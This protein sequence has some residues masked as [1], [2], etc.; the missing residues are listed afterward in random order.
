V[1]K[2]LNRFTGHAAYWKVP[3]SVGLDH[4]LTQPIDI[5]WIKVEAGLYMFTMVGKSNPN[6]NTVKLKNSKNRRADLEN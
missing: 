3:P 6:Q 1:P 2:R 5:V 4:V